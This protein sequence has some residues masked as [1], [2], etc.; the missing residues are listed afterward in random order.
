MSE[1]N[2]N[3]AAVLDQEQG[4]AQ[5]QGRPQIAD[6]NLAD[7]NALKEEITNLLKVS[8][9]VMEGAKEVLGGLSKSFEQRDPRGLQ[10]TIDQFTTL[11]NDRVNAV[12]RRL[13]ALNTA[14]NRGINVTL[15]TKEG[16]VTANLPRIVTTVMPDPLRANL[17]A[18]LKKGQYVG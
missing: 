3:G 5:G 8:D 15:Q 16:R 13:A 14:H 4:Q 9:A 17:K 7:A 11:L 2:N 6:I 1:Q 10:A 12:A 18:A